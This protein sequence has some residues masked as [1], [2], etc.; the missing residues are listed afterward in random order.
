MLNFRLTFHSTQKK[1]LLT[2]TSPENTAPQATITQPLEGAVFN[3]GATIHYNGVGTD[4]EDG[5]LPG[6]AF[7]WQAAQVGQSFQTLTSGV[8][9]GSVTAPFSGSF[10]LRLSVKDSGGLTAIDEVSITVGQVLNQPPTA[11]ITQPKNGDLFVRGQTLSYAGNGTDPED[12]IL[13]A[14]AF[15]WTAVGGGQTYPLSVDAKS[16]AIAIPLGI[17]PG[18]YPIKPNHLHFTSNRAVTR[19]YADFFGGERNPLQISPPTNN[20]VRVINISL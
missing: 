1:A 19:I 2:V 7:T 18:N 6:Q 4:V 20:A 14:S 8:K 5:D 3:V 10:I 13:P 17:Q 12:G 11:T 9:S 16:G 15:T